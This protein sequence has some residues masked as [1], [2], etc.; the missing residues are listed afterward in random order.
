MSE[1]DVHVMFDRLFP[2]GFAGP[3]VLDE[4]APKGWEQSPL[5]A[6]F[7][8]SV[9]RVYQ[10]LVL[11]HRNLQ[12]LGSLRRRRRGSAVDVFSPAPALED[13]RKEV[14]LSPVAQDAE[15]AELVG[16]GPG[17]EVAASLA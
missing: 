14:E 9:E 8:P 2:R 16:L 15:V 5:L 3:D 13:V 7:H 4:I 1:A 6:C 12:E 11:M 10:E 17:A